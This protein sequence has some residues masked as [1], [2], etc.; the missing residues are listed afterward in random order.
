[1]GTFTRDN[2]EIAISI[3]GVGQ[4]HRAVAGGM[5]IAL[6][7][8]GAGLD[9]SEMFADL[10]GGACQEAHFGYVLTGAAT[11]TYSDGGSERLRGRS[12]LLPAS[13]PQRPHRR[14]RRVR[15]VHPG[16][17]HSGHQHPRGVVRGRPHDLG[18]A[19]DCPEGRRCPKRE[20]PGG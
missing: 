15:G 20:A 5:S 7:H 3:E 12:G 17:R 1:M 10:P 11:V 18:L 13:G 4:Q 14:G 16:E 8:W 2:T 19:C 9:T 6:E